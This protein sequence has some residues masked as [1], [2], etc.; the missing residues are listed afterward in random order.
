MFLYIYVKL[1]HCRTMVLILM[2]L[3]IRS[4]LSAA[5]VAAGTAGTLGVQLVSNLLWFSS[6]QTFFLPLLFIFSNI[7]YYCCGAGS[8]SSRKWTHPSKGTIKKKRKEKK[9]VRWTWHELCSIVAAIF[10]DM[11][12]LRSLVGFWDNY[13]QNFLSGDFG[14]FCFFPLIVISDG[15]NFH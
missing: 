3:S 12:L 9:E 4:R 14:D 2:I 5:S 8:R 13:H 10:N 7:C 1:L 15:G 6:H 11:F